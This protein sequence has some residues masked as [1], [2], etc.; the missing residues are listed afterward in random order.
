M[1][2]ELDIWPQG[3]AGVEPAEFSIWSPAQPVSYVGTCEGFSLRKCIRCSWTCGVQKGRL[4]VLLSGTGLHHCR[5]HTR[6]C[7]ARCLKTHT[8]L[9][10]CQFPLG[11]ELTVKS[12][13]CWSSK[14]PKPLKLQP[15]SFLSLSIFNTLLK[16]SYNTLVY[17]LPSEQPATETAPAFRPELRTFWVKSQLQQPHSGSQKGSHGYRSAKK[18]VI[19]CRCKAGDYSQ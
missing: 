14:E 6:C 18:P 2:K 16:L 3:E 15:F 17:S 5:I 8:N 1:G 13:S 11:R 12:L 4:V 10:W 7:I 19:V 9:P